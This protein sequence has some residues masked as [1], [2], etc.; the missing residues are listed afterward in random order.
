MMH[1]PATKVL[2]AHQRRSLLPTNTFGHVLPLISY[3][4]NLLPRREHMSLP[5]RKY[6]SKCLSALE[7]PYRPPFIALVRATRLLNG[8]RLLS[9]GTGGGGCRAGGGGGPFLPFLSAGL[10]SNLFFPPSLRRESPARPSRRSRGGLG[11]RRAARRFE[12]GLGL[13]PPRCTGDLEGDR[14]TARLGRSSAVS[15]RS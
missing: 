7:D 11:D 5:T 10:S 2:V 8:L 3:Y 15:M 4:N 9:L 14:E 6:S 12:K 1:A 13:R